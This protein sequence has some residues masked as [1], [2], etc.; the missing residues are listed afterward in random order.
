MLILIPLGL[1]G[2]GYCFWCYA[3]TEAYCFFCPSIDTRYAPGF[4]EERFSQIRSGM[5]AQAVQE[6]LGG[7]L[8]VQPYVE[9]RKEGELWFSTLDG[10]CK[11][12]DWAWLCRQ[13]DFREGRAV[14]VI[15]RVGYD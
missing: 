2:V 8:Y 14:A 6:V 5:T 9:D 15:R 1:I 13:V 10:K 11:W 7:P 3:H 12:G 4:S